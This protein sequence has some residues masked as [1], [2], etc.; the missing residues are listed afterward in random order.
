LNATEI[1]Q[2]E[3]AGSLIDLVQKHVAADGERV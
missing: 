1:A 3:N 2:M